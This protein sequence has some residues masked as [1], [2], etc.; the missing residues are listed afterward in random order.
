MQASEAHAGRAA[1]RRPDGGG[2]HPGGG[3]SIELV[4][5]PAA[6]AD[7]LAGIDAAVV[8]VDVERS[9]ADR[10]YRRAALVQ[11]G[12]GRRC[13][14][15][16]ALAVA[17]LAALGTYLDGRLAVVHAVDN[18][19]EPLQAAGVELSRVA[20]T[21][22]AAAV[23]GLPTGLA[24]LVEE[25]LGTTL[26]GDKQRFQ[27]ADWEARPLAR[28]LLDYAARDVVELPR[29]WDE[30]AA[31]LDR[32]GRRDW[33]QQELA[34]IVQRA[35]TPT[36]HWRRTSGVDG[37]SQPQRAVLRAVW[38]EREELARGH[39]IA[40]QHL[41][42]DR[43]LTGLA[44]D[45]P[46]SPG[47]LVQRARRPDLVGDH[48]ARLFAAVQRG[49]RAPPEE[50]PAD[51]ADDWTVAAVRAMRRARAKIARRIG[52]DP[53]VVCPSRKLRPAVLAAPSG[54]EE[55]CEQAGLRPWQRSLLREA[56]WAAYTASRPPASRG[57]SRGRAGGRGARS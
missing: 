41:L 25:L 54:P 45:P 11:V 7:S 27:R 29:L 20:D 42:H 2:H 34:A 4:A 3:I 57:P 32:A 35:R 48:A 36:R 50:L 17:D 18:D 46:P 5:D 9:D 33:Y 23:L 38:E 44:T 30:L 56:L 14:L 47:E 13:V 37:L 52:L 43:V 10:Y 6:V 21:A 1:A 22:V 12:A 15:I 55:L 51:R 19:I 53:G 40:P 26:T 31:R 49:R 39:D 16:D 28:E 24:T 8:G